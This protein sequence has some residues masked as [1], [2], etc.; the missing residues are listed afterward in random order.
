MSRKTE[1]YKGLGKK[2]ARRQNIIAMGFIQ[3]L[4]AQPF[5]YRA[6]FACKLVGLTW[7]KVAWFVIV[8][9]GVLLVAFHI[10]QLP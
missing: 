3:Q 8:S 4:N 2:I 10:L 1:L 5:R 7:Y 9:G 6:A